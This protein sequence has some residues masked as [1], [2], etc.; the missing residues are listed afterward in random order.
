MSA[1]VLPGPVRLCLIGSSCFQSAIIDALVA[2]GIEVVCL[3]NQSLGGNDDPIE[4]C[5]RTNGLFS[6]N[7]DLARRIGATFLYTPDVNSDEAIAAIKST[8][9]NIVLSCS[10]P[11]LRKNFIGAFDGWV[12][13]YHGSRR[14]RGRAGASWS[15]L[16][17][18]S[19]DSVVLHWIDSGIDTG[20]W[21]S[22]ASYGWG[23][24][25]YP[26][27]IAKAQVP[28]FEFLSRQLAE[29]LQV[30]RF[31]SLESESDRPYLPSL[32]THVDGLVDW[33][34]SAGQLERA[35]RAFGWP[36]AGLSGVLEKSDRRTRVPVRLARVEVLSTSGVLEHP[37][38]VGAVVSRK[39]DR[40]ADVQ[41]GSGVVRVHSV[42]ADLEERP[43][44][45]VVTLGARFIVDVHSGQGYQ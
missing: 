8:G 23:E 43:A 37:L 17:G 45:S 14:Y 33:R 18:H 4:R 9:A 3:A 35:V 24:E 7:E 15:I 11:V 44:A 1:E 13:N 20:Q 31:P 38:A 2:G 32:V 22:S 34:W 26:L 19:E 6:A 12:L 27:D 10:A 29:W 16:G 36:Y 40:W 21:I 41:C 39:S 5:Y 42:R 28:A 30:G 25:S